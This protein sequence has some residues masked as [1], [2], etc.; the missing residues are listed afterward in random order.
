MFSLSRPRGGPQKTR[1]AGGRPG[2]QLA[3]GQS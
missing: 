1:P 2:R 3:G